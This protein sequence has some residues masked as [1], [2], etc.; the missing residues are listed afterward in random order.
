[1]TVP[2]NSVTPENVI[3]EESFHTFR[4]QLNEEEG[5]SSKEQEND[6]CRSPLKVLQC[7]PDAN[8]CR[9]FYSR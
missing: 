3:I 1:M 7:Q 4:H 2:D 8:V 5:H 9:Y 6:D